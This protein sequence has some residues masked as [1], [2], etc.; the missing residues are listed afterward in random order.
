[1]EIEVTPFLELSA[2]Q[3]VFV[4]TQMPKYEDGI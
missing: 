4:V 3:N 1:M 2:V